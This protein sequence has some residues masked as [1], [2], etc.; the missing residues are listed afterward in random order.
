METIATQIS[1][2][3]SGVRI[4]PICDLGSESGCDQFLIGAV[5]QLATNTER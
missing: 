1:V 4:I 3:G 2:G 5:K